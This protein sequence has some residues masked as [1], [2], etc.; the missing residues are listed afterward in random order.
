MFELAFSKGKKTILCGVFLFWCLQKMV[1]GASG[2]M[3]A[4]IAREAG[5][6]L[7]RVL[8]REVRLKITAKLK[9]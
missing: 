5:E 1:I 3:V 7:S 9:K 8:L 2:Q 6:D 4:Q